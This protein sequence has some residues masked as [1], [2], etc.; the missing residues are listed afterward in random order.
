MAFDNPLAISGVD[1]P[2]VEYRRLLSAQF[3]HFGQVLSAQPGVLYG[4]GVTV[5]GLVATV[6]VGM[7]LLSPSP[8][9]NGSYLVANS[10]DRGFTL[11]AQDSTYGRLDRVIVRVY[12]AEI[13]GHG[14]DKAQAEIVTGTP[15]ATPV[16]PPLPE[17][18]LDL[19][20]LQVGKV[21]QPIVAV[22]QRLF[23]S[24]V[25]A[26]ILA[27][28]YAALTGLGTPSRL[29]QLAITSD[30][31]ILWMWNGSRWVPQGVPHFATAEARELGI[32]APAAGDMCTV[33]SGSNSVAL[34]FGSEWVQYTL[35]AKADYT[36]TL[37][38][39]TLGTT[40]AAT[41]TVSYLSADTV[42]VDFVC[43][44]GTGGKGTG[45]ILV[46]IPPSLGL[47]QVGQAFARRGQGVP[48]P[49]ICYT[50]A[51]TALAFVTTSSNAIVNTTVPQTWTAGDTLAGYIIAKLA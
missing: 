9:A 14:E 11:T 19:S 18:A 2:A 48:I 26:P 32:P 36:P 37:T 20:Y 1:I 46:N 44:F 5:S 28:N 31:Q 8:G 24:S 10:S 13:D 45:T 47:A 15:S 49:L 17:G 35:P 30:Y 27:A 22:D 6:Q 41:G 34:V 4:L 33:G 39:G 25:G 12:D 23:T 40:G 7:A 21:G 16:L 42:R 38:N 3:V 51:N 50:A 43:A 29:G